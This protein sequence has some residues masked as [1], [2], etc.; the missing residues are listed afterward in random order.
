MTAWISVD[1]HLPAAVLAAALGLAAVVPAG[2]QQASIAL[3]AAQKSAGHI[4]VGIES[5]YPPMAAMP[6][7]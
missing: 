1:R 3:P 7:C 6:P 4:G 5:T 2:A